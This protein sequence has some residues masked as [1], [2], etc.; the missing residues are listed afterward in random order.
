MRAIDE[1]KA[2]ET[3]TDSPGEG[4]GPT[5]AAAPPHSPRNTAAAGQA[6]GTPPITGT[7]T[8]V[9]VAGSYRAVQIVGDPTVAQ[10]YVTG[11]HRVDQ[12]GT[13]LLVSSAGPLDEQPG[14]ERPRGN[15]SFLGGFS[16]SDLPRTINWARS[17]KD[18]QLILRV[19]PELLVELEATGAEVKV[20][21]LVGGLQ[22]RVVACSL[23]AE[24][25][26]GALDVEA[27]SSSVKISAV[28]TGSGRI[29]AESSSVR[30]TL[31]EGSNVRIRGINRMGRLQLPDRPA[32]TLP[33]EDQ[34]TESVIGTGVDQLSVESVM[35][36][37]TVAA[38]A[39][40]ETAR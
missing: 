26:R 39:W 6:G 10:L 17:W 34:N 15:G 32:S 25:L 30:L 20:N 31:L 36:S 37:V 23:K 11:P 14:G 22:A 40:E 18:H 13:T 19:N 38:Q 12:Q 7:V 24:K 16:F 4:T 2:R 8:S 27:T 3:R 21:G 1:Q 5:P 9:R 28:P 35:S 29:Y 33:L